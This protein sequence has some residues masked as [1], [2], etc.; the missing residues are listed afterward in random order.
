MHPIFAN[1]FGGLSR[2]YYIRQCLFG[3]IF[4]AMLVLA[5]TQSPQHASM[6]AALAFPLVVNTLL[7]PYSRFVYESI[8]RYVT[9]NHLFVVNAFL[10]LFVKLVTMALCWSMA[11]FLAPVGLAWL[12][13]HHTR[14]EKPALPR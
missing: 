14:A 9:G 8:V 2:A 1:T 11:L 4:P 10:L 12:Y 3:L 7:Y 6:P 13:F 5:F